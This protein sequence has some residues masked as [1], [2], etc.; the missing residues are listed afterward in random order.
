M[1][2]SHL[3]WKL[4]AHEQPLVSSPSPDF[5]ISVSAKCL[6]KTD[7]PTSTLVV[8]V[9]VKPKDRSK[10]SFWQNDNGYEI[11]W[12]VLAW[13]E[14]NAIEQLLDNL[15]ANYEGKIAFALTQE[16]KEQLIQDFN[17]QCDNIIANKIILKHHSNDQDFIKNNLLPNWSR[18]WDLRK[19]YLN[20][21]LLPDDKAFL[22]QLIN[23]N[24]AR[25]NAYLS[26]TNLPINVEADSEKVSSS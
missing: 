22:D 6:I 14:L 1:L 26:A 17:G 15:F 18:F 10:P 20:D 19:S 16:Q 24:F 13:A 12:T 2:T 8:A 23:D 9:F 3:Q 25:Y 5:P 21:E 11:K 4:F 7:H